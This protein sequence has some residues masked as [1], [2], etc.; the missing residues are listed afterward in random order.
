MPMLRT[1]PMRDRQPISGLLTEVKNYGCNSTDYYS[2]N[3]GSVVL[4][5]LLLPRGDCALWE[6]SEQAGK[7]G[8]VAAIVYGFPKHW[9]GALQY[10]RRHQ[11]AIFSTTNA[12][13]EPYP[14]IL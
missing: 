14:A 2:D 10:P 13:A 11:I 5:P 6:I 7:A 9:E 1:P 4:I 3:N 8:A 12:D